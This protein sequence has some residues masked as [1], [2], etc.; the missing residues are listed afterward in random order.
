M[1]NGKNANLDIKRVYFNQKKRGINGF[2][3]LTIDKGTYHRAKYEHEILGLL[4]KNPG[5]EILFH[6]R[7]PTSTINT[8]NTAHPICSNDNF[9]DHKYY[10]VH[11]GVIRNAATLYTKHTDAGLKYSSIVG[12]GEYHRP[13]FNDSES[14]LLELASIIDGGKTL[15]KFTAYGSMAFIMLQ[16][17]NY[18]R[19][20]NLYYGRNEGSPLKIKSDADKVVIASDIDG[21]EITADKL[22]K[23]CYLDGKNSSEN[24]KFHHY[25]SPDENDTYINGM[26]RTAPF[27]MVPVT[28]ALPSPIETPTQR[29]SIM[30]HSY[31]LGN[32]D[33]DDSEL[34][35]EVLKTKSDEELTAFEED[36]QASLEVIDRSFLGETDQNEIAR[37]KEDRRD[38]HEG[39]AKVDAE[40]KRRVEL[41]S[42]QYDD[43]PRA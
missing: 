39:L 23:F 29:M 10:L 36:F 43:L 1:A 21:A 32:D 30:D 2:G 9:P 11:N 26:R 40:I 18:G 7:N 6:H 27:T 13:I 16:T 34:D 42:K 25:Y 37:L 14:L 20:L 31:G 35:A 15:D 12:E 38:A 4:H 3:F 8:D 28:R 22:N 41:N 24:M 5:C 33:V 17:D 19:P